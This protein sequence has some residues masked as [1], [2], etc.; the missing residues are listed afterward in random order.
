VD[1]QMIYTGDIPTGEINNA[2]RSTLNIADSKTSYMIPL[3]LN[4]QTISLLLCYS[5]ADSSKKDIPLNDFDIV[6]KKISYAFQIL[7]LK[8]RI[9]AQNA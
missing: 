7:F 4:N 6:A 5:F 8:K 2:V 9:M 3:L 1:K